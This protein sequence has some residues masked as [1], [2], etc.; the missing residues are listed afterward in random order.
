M[1]SN[2]KKTFDINYILLIKSIKKYLCSIVFF[3]SI[4][5]LLLN[6][7]FNFIFFLKFRSKFSNQNWY[8]TDNDNI[9]RK[10]QKQCSFLKKKC[11]VSLITIIIFCE[12]FEKSRDWDRD[13]INHIFSCFVEK[14]IIHICYFYFYLNSLIFLNKFNVKTKWELIMFKYQNFVFL[15]FNSFWTISIFVQRLFETINVKTKTIEIKYL[16]FNS[17]FFCFCLMILFFYWRF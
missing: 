15:F 16:N 10:K 12:I 9:F 11:D 4:I 13:Y 7:S 17:T 1:L 6:K 8:T 2:L 5:I 3:A 14:N